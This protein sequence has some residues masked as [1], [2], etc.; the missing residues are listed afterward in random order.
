MEP[1][2]DWRMTRTARV[3]LLLVLLASSTPWAQ[4]A[5]D[6][7]ARIDRLIALC[8]LWGAVKYFH[9]YLAYRGDIDWDK[10]LLATI[11]EV[12]AA[13]S[14][15]DYAT[16]VDHMLQALGDPVSAVVRKTASAA[17]LPSTSDRPPDPSFKVTE[18]RILLVNMTHYSDLADLAGGFQ[19]AD[20]LK[21]E[22]PKAR[23]VIF[24]LR[25]PAL[26]SEDE[27]GYLG[28]FFN[29]VSLDKS[30]TSSPI[31]AP[32]ERRRMHVGFVPQRGATPG[33]YESGL[34]I[35]LSQTIVPNPG[36]NDVP[37]LFLVNKNSEL[38]AVSLALQS[39]GKG[40]IVAEG[41]AGDAS[42]VTTQRLRLSDG[43]EAEI[44]LGELLYGDGTGGFQ[45]D[46]I[47]PA[48]ELVGDQNPTLQRALELARNFKISAT[49]RKHVPASAATLPDRPYADLSYPP[50]EYR[51]L[52]AFRIWNVINY[53]FP[54]KDLMGEDWEGVLREFIPRLETAGS[55]L[56][57]NLTIAEMVTHIHD[58][59]GFV[60][61]PL[62]NDYF[63]T[64]PAPVRLRMIEG[65]PVITGFMDE[66][67]ARSAGADL[68]DV[69]LKV[70]G[71]DAIVRISRVARYISASTSQW[72]L[73]RAAGA[74]LGGAENSQAA[75]TVRDRE[76][77]I[78][79]L[80]LPRRKAFRN[81]ATERTG[82]PLKVL[83]GN[84]GY[85]DLDRLTVPMVDA[86]FEKFKDTTAIVFD[87]R[88]YPLGTAW[89]IGP[90]LSAKDSVVAAMFQRRVAMFPDAPMGELASQ[91]VTQT[92]AQRMPHTD[93]WRY[94]GRTVMLIDERTIS[95]AEHTGLFFEA[96]NGTKFV[97]SPT[98]GADGDVTNFCVPGG[99]W[100]SF[101]GQGVRHADGRQLQRVGLAPDVEVRPT[102]K[103]IRAGKDEVLDRAVQYLQSNDH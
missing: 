101:T 41:G 55:A 102:L 99:I 66:Q 32:G 98:A 68:G 77:H 95:H 22:I 34:Y 35:S 46:L 81:G 103:G 13:K 84:I 27:S 97:G 38:P 94:K 15:D 17:P 63:G 54:Y 21:K 20:A 82:D 1:K 37:V 90:R 24:D 73:Y 58:G 76:D 30:L 39:A 70:D 64:S 14:G 78:K 7:S 100:I 9:P 28:F 11:P 2:V 67:A 47:V 51:M 86:M 36:T 89:A 61:S 29:F 12:N 48:S 75:V 72:Q 5:G 74:L 71:E 16:A 44:R 56:D 33:G 62:L 79:E 23:A 26:V 80:K 93:T 92:F 53:F 40:A 10:A 50:V 31:A 4:Q 8:K 52:A 43:V 42:A 60:Q 49:S 88:T 45:P 91:A 87:D 6:G 83:P 18:D 25:A 69:I 59:H 57:Y 85:A 19:R 65:V 3:V 96:A